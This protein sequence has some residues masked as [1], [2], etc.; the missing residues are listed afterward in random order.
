MITQVQERAKNQEDDKEDLEANEEQ[1]HTI[2]SSMA[3]MKQDVINSDYL[4]LATASTVSGVCGAG[5]PDCY[6][7]G[8]ISQALS[9]LMCRVYTD[10]VDLD[11]RI[12]QVQIWN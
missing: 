4:L 12:K 11:E 8:G 2:N 6:T 7:S 3:N 5:L 9:R 10:W 1:F